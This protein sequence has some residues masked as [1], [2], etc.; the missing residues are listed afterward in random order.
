M[1]VPGPGESGECG[2]EQ[3]VPVGDRQARGCGRAVRGRLCGLQHRSRYRPLLTQRFQCLPGKGTHRR[4]AEQQHPDRGKHGGR[5]LQRCELL[6]EGLR[7]VLL[8]VVD[9]HEPGQRNGVHAATGPG[10]ETREPA[11]GSHLFAQ[12][13]PESGLARSAVSIDIADGEPGP[14]LAP[15]PCQ[16]QLFIPEGVSDDAEL[17]A[18][19]QRGSRCPLAAE[20]FGPLEREVLVPVLPRAL[21]AQVRVRDGQR[22]VPVVAVAP[23]MLA[24]E[25]QQL[26]AQGYQLWR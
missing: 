4:P 6:G 19:Q 10:Q 9:D 12:L 1:A 20:V 26:T 22:P 21:H 3:R 11:A 15:P 23:G 16:G 14:G 2:A 17:C 7:V 5:T 18:Q 25:R 13:D 8:D 24:V